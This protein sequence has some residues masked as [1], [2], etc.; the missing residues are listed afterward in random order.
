MGRRRAPIPLA[1]TVVL[2]AMADLDDAIKLLT[3][4]ANVT[5]MGATGPQERFSVNTK[6]VL[7]ALRNAGAGK[8]EAHE[9]ALEALGKL[10]GGAEIGASRGAQGGSRGD[11]QLEAWWIPAEAVRFS[12]SE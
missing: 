8:A 2:A 9:L 3:D 12:D 4:P 6:R 1:G 11:R 5:R 7:R 10:E